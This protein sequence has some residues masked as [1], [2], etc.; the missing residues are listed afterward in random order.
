MYSIISL[1]C[2]NGFVVT[3]SDPGKGIKLVKSEIKPRG[4]LF[5]LWG[6]LVYNVPRYKREDYETIARKI[7]RPTEE[8]WKTWASHSRDAILGNLTSGEERA[9]MVLKALGGPPEVAADM[10]HYEAE[11][12]SGKVHFF[13]G[14]PAML[15]TLRQRGYRTCL[16]SNCN[17]LT[18]GVVERL[19]LP[20]MLDEIIL[21]CQ[22]KMAK[23]DKAIYELAA[24]RL[25]LPTGDCLFVGDGGD[26]ELD[27]AKA[28]G[29]KV[30]LVA[31]ERG[32]AYRFPQKV[33]PYDIRLNKV[34]DLLHFLPESAPKIPAA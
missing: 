21:S 32:H 7:G 9:R 34:T 16:I 33:Y 24:G 31:Q 22:V 25:G 14:V 4:I 17:Y 19:G 6:T 5:D 8:I 27:G 3:G 12:L 30:A 15:E 28:A 10:V 1:K 29:C 13:E 20:E 18:P 11:N 2:V 26:G 23:P